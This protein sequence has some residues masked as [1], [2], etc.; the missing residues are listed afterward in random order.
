MIVGHRDD[1]LVLD[2]KVGKTGEAEMLGEVRE[3][4]LQDAFIALD[5][6]KIGQLVQPVLHSIPPSVITT[7]LVV[8]VR[9]DSRRPGAPRTG[10]MARN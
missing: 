7:I 5:C 2:V 4:G 3:P 9:L 6:G 1:M 10:A 8:A